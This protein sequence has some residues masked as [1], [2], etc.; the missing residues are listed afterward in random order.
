MSDQN[1]PQLPA[2]LQHNPN[3]PTFT[4]QQLAKQKTEEAF[5]M[6]ETLMNDPEQEG[7]VRLGAAKEILDR[8]WGKASTKIDITETKVDLNQMQND[9]LAHLKEVDAKAAEAR[10]IE[11]ESLGLYLTVDAE[12]VE[13]TASHSEAALQNNGEGRGNPAPRLHLNPAPD[14]VRSPAPPGG[15][16]HGA[17]ADSKAS[18]D[19]VDYNA[20]L[21]R[22]QAQLRH[23]W[24]EDADIN[25]QG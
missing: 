17:N 12:L 1:N 16:G 3:R 2:T 15:A 5:K 14:L 13:D 11:D 21:A 20:K 19:Y 18:A 10:K 24:P 6:L 4:L 22:I 9:L 8:G 23:T 25:A 7:H